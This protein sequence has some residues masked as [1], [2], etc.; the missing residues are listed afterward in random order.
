MSI[1]IVSDRMIDLSKE[2]LASLKIDTMSCYVNMDGKSYS[3][4][5]DV[6]PEDI[7]EYMDKTGNVAQTAAKS[8]DL[9]TEFF[10]QYVDKGNTVIHFATSSGISSVAENAKTA[11]ANFP[12]KVF[13]IDTLQLSN[14]IALLV[15][16]ALK[17][18]ADGEMDA[19][20]IA[21]LVT[22]R[23]PKVKCSFLLDTLDCI[24]KGGRCSGMTYYAA[25]I[26]KIKPVIY[27]DEMGRMVVR[28]KFRGSQ[29]KILER[30]ISDTFSTFPDP[31]L[32]QLYISYSTY[33][34]SVQQNILSIVA[35]YHDFKNIQFNKQ[36]CNCCIHSGENSIA[37][38]YMCK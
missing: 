29:E 3:D 14:G 20:K 32:D 4:L 2:E 1:K 7:F 37:V 31:D 18:I 10:K 24:Y 6:F 13:V 38:F 9:Y 33:N 36:G 19:E 34:E 28:K 22:Q 11:A 15:K 26:F 12:G 27:M 8:P 17:L 25:N 23:I 30:F 16:Y 21:L 5:D 35:K